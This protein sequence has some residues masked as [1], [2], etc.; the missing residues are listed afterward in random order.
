MSVPNTARHDALT[1]YRSRH[2]GSI[3]GVWN[4]VVVSVLDKVRAPLR[5]RR[6]TF[7][8]GAKTLYLV[9]P[10]TATN[11]W[12]GL[13]IP[14]EKQVEVTMWH[15][16]QPYARSLSNLDGIAVFSH[17]LAGPVRFVYRPRNACAGW[18]AEVQTEWVLIT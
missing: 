15:G 7:C 6:I 8:A 17:L 12:A 1:A 13:I 16:G 18:E 10:D 14:G 2:P 11:R 5:V 4:D 9:T 3:A